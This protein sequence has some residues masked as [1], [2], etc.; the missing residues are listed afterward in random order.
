MIIQK[1][2]GGVNDVVRTAFFLRRG[3]DVHEY[4]AA[5]AA[6]TTAA[7]DVS[8]GENPV[9]LK[10]T[11]DAPSSFSHSPIPLSLYFPFI[12]EKD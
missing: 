1:P 6:T 3:E 12:D 2:T 4:E 7:A 11:T 5:A 10:Y 9:G 8:A